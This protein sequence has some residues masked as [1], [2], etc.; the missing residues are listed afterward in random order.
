MHKICFSLSDWLHSVWQTLGPLTSLQMTHFFSFSGWVISHWIRLPHLL[1]PSLCWGTFR[2]LLCPG[3]HK[4]CFREHWGVCAQLLSHVWF[5]V[6]PWT[7]PCKAPLSMKFSKQ[8]CCSG[9]P[10]S[11]S[12]N[13]EVYVSFWIMVFSGCLPRPEWNWKLI[14]RTTFQTVI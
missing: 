8:E 5:F 2:L 14:L 12:R 6:S 3:Y 13:I 7:L 1:P 11:Y 9:L 4:E 10:F